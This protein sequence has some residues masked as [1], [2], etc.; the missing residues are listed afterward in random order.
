[1]QTTFVHA[2]RSIRRGVRPHVE[3]AWLFAIARNVCRER[4]RSTQRRGASAR[5]RDVDELAD[6]LAAPEPDDDELFDLDAALGRLA[7]RQREALLLREWRGL[8]YEEIA[9]RLDVS[10]SAVETLLFRA[11]RSLAHE[12]EHDTRGVLG[13]L[14]LLLGMPRR[15]WHAGVTT[16]LAAGAAAVS[17]A[18]VAGGVAPRFVNHDRAP[19]RHPVVRA[20]E[21]APARV[22]VPHA[23]AAPPVRRHRAPARRHVA[24]HIAPPVATTRVAPAVAVRSATTAAPVTPPRTTAT[25]AASPPATS[26]PPTASTPPPAAPV[27][28]AADPAPQPPPDASP[29]PVSAQATVAPVQADLPP[30]RLQTPPV[31][32]PAPLPSVP[33]LTVQTPAVEVAVPATTVQV[34]VPPLQSL[35]PPVQL[36]PVLP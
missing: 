15:L 4:W 12:L 17:I 35:V 31:Q 30:V 10:E 16:K 11:R 24:Q 28:A 5:T 3:A 9:R 1:M 25:G 26:T 6:V 14:G 18:V 2:L 27:N 22:V 21:A 7:E 36:P 19:G 33:P 8:S 34:T 23:V 32:L 13:A 20:A 29:P